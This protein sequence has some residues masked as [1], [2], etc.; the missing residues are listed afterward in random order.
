[1][2]NQQVS[3]TASREIWRLF[4][5]RF[6]PLRTSLAGASL[7]EIAQFLRTEADF[8][9]LQKPTNTLLAR[10]FWNTVLV[11]VLSAYHDELARKRE[12]AEVEQQ[13]N[14]ARKRIEEARV[15]KNVTPDTLIQHARDHDRWQLQLD[16]RKSALNHATARLNA[17]LN[18]QNEIDDTHIQHV[19]S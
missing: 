15:N 5:N 7:D 18:P 16:T 11:P 10:I 12:L 17:L 9:A 19:N 6:E 8:V 14:D 1:M 2:I 3:A 13:I 4:T